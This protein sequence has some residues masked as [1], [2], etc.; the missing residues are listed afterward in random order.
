M[1]VKKYNEFYIAENLD[2]DKLSAKLTEDYKDL[3]SDLIDIINDTMEETS[4]ESIKNEDLLSFID[5]Y[6]SKGKDSNLLD[7][8]IEDNDIFNFYLKHQSDIDE[9]LNSS[10]YMDKTPKENN[11]FSLYDVIMDG[12]KESIIE[13]FKLLKKELQ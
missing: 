6:I 11:V 2:L 3:K 8:L 7:G 9:L 1:E 13:V 4:D 5:E 12:T 10:K